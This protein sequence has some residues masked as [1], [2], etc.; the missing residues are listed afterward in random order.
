MILS[1]LGAA[2]NWEL[3]SLS[4]DPDFDTPKA[5]ADY[6]TL[7]RGDDTS[8]WLFAASPAAALSDL[9]PRLGLMVMRQGPGITHNLR[10]VVVDPQGRVFRQFDGNGW[11]PRQLADAIL[12][13]ARLS[14]TPTPNQAP[15][16]NVHQN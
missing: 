12:E 2:T 3:M 9:A 5:L 8:H 1:T 7:Y 4:F 15:T 16:E 13:A 14:V 10:T 11:T 6:A